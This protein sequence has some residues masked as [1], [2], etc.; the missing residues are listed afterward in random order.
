MFRKFQLIYR[1]SSQKYVLLIMYLYRIQSQR[2]TT[3]FT[4]VCIWSI[5]KLNKRHL[6][7]NMGI[8][9]D[10]VG[11]ML[12][13]CALNRLSVKP[14]PEQNSAN[15]TI[16]AGDPAVKVAFING[17]LSQLGRVAKTDRIKVGRQCKGCVPW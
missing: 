10:V 4:Y 12:F 1:V 8:Q 7:N 9:T 13:P 15:I 16:P 2:L 17:F 6:F 3:G 14:F 11:I 5:S